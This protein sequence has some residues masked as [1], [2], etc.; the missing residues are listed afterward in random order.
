M[1]VNKVTQWSLI[2][3]FDD[4][5]PDLFDSLD[6]LYTAQQFRQLFA[7][8]HFFLKERSCSASPMQTQLPFIQS[9]CVSQMTGV[10]LMLNSP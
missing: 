2:S 10:K 1:L 8:L 4:Y 5:L 6:L 9:M 7:F 3:N